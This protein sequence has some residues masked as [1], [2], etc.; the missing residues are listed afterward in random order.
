M[1]WVYLI[2]AI[3]GEMIAT[4]SLKESAG[5]TKLTPSIITVIGYSLTF[6]FLSLALKQIPIGVAYAVWAGVG[7]LLIAIVG[8]FRFHQKLDAPAIAG[9]LLII[10][11]VMIM[12]VFSKTL[13][14]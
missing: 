4:S 3:V 9:M 6:Y 2:I 8:Y 13:S 10:S 14:N 1:K 12:Q 5:F 11:G 7:I